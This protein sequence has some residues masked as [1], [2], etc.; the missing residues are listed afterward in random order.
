MEM[1]SYWKDS[2]YKQKRVLVTGAHGFLGQRVTALLKHEGASVFTPSRDR[3][4]LMVPQSIETY[5]HK[6]RPEYGVSSFDMIFHL[7]GLVG[8]IGAVR[9]KPYDSISSN[10]STTINLLD[11]LSYTKE[12]KTK[13]IFAGSV[14]AYPLNAPM[15]LKESDLWNGHPEPTNGPYGVAKR[16]ILSLAEAFS[17]QYG[18][19]ICYALLAN[20]FGPGD[21]YDFELSH[22]IPSI[23]LKTHTA[24]I[25]G[26]STVNLWGS[27]NPTRD[28]LYVDDAAEALVRMGLRWN[29]PEPINI[30][31]GKEISIREVAHKIQYYMNWTGDYIWDT[32]KPDGQPRRI[33]DISRANEV[34]EW[35]PTTFFQS[36][37]ELTISDY[38]HRMGKF[39]EMA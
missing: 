39:R 21:N 12:T 29:N 16:A 4:N 24:I 25:K 32:T 10:L 36:G 8:G 18:N 6:N 1:P 20:M 35:Q 11:A 3:M 23:I 33:L 17:A 5:L 19:P 38:M 34:L 9:S 27:G 22:V 26:H 13:V 15:P 2:P 14:C 37:I 30:G 7:A 31:S 28:F